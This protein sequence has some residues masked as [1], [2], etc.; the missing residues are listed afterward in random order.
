MDP[1]PWYLGIKVPPYFADTAKGIDTA[2]VAAALDGTTATGVSVA[3]DLHRIQWNSV[4]QA[5]G[6]G[7]YNWETT[8]KEVPAGTWTITTQSEPQALHVPLAEGGEYVL[9]AHASDAQGHSARATQRG[10]ATTTIA[11]TSFRRRSAIAPV[12]RRAS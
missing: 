3:V 5:A 10:P 8:R 12:R 11:S 9:I 6:N 4:R 7:F 2:I 1:A